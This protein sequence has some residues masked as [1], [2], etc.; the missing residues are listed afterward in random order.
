MGYRR[1]AGQVGGVGLGSDFLKLHVADDDVSEARRRVGVEA[2]GWLGGGRVGG[3]G[4]GFGEMESW[5]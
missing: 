3:D 5:S 2:A 4:S 1:C